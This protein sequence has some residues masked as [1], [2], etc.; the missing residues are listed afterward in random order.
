MTDVTRKDKNQITVGIA[1]FIQEINYGAV[2]QAFALGTYIQQLGYRV[3]YVD[4]KPVPDMCPHRPVKKLFYYA[5]VKRRIDTKR[6]VF[7][8]FKNQWMELTDCPDSVDILVCGSDQ[9]WNTDITGGF[10]PLFFGDLT[11]QN[12]AYA[13]SCG[14]VAVLQKNS[15]LFAEK[16]QNFYAVSSRENDLAD[17]VRETA[18]MP[19]PVVCDPTFLLPIGA[20][21]PLETVKRPVKGDYLLVYQMNKNAW[22]YKVA[23]DIAK[24]KKLKIVEINNNMFDYQLCAHKCYYS[25]EVGKFLALFKHASYVVTNSFHGTAFSLLYEKNFAVIKSRS[26]N[27]RIVDLCRTLGLENRVLEQAGQIPEWITADIDYKRVKENMLPY[28]ATSQQYLKRSL[29]MENQ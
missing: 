18:T 4:T 22:V 1:T 11:K 13:A 3:C 9:I 5:V 14:D 16:L 24:K 25:G 10:D 8:E 27:S 29:Q 20:Y 15:A 21:Q 19:C 23:K 7:A 6:R 28:V 26:R 17:F 12:I 2:L